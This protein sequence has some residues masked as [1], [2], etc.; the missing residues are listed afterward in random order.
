MSKRDIGTGPGE[1]K[2]E[3]KPLSAE[4]AHHEVKRASTDFTD[5]I[6]IPDKEDFMLRL[7][8]SSQNALKQTARAEGFP[9]SQY[10]ALVESSIMRHLD[11]LDGVSSTIITDREKYP[12]TG[13]AF[14]RDT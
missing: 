13:I 8:T 7:Q 2:E 12:P 10:Y 3:K 11:H 9:Y 1:G 14:Y 5:E 6:L 4:P